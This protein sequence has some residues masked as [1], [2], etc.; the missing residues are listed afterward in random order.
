[1]AKLQSL[2]YLWFG[3]IFVSNVYSLLTYS[4]SSLPVLH[5]NLK[6][7]GESS[8][9]MFIESSTL[10]HEDVMCFYSYTD[11]EW[12]EEKNRLMQRSLSVLRRHLQTVQG[13]NLLLMSLVPDFGRVYGIINFTTLGIQIGSSI[14]VLVSSSDLSS[15]G[16]QRGFLSSRIS[17]WCPRCG[18]C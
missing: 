12:Q 8:R 9:V 3:S 4:E 11:L 7:E 5:G 13:H 6:K 1:M 18:F 2:G 15:A 17:R 16:S 10:I 14:T